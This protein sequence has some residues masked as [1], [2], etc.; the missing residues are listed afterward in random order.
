MWGALGGA[1]V[2][3]TVAWL[4]ALDLR[5]R[6]RVERERERIED[7]ADRQLDRDEA[8][9]DRARER[10]EL[11]RLE[12][13]VELRRK[14]RPTLRDITD[15]LRD[16][17]LADVTDDQAD[18]EELGL[19]IAAQLIELEPRLEGEDHDLVSALTRFIQWPSPDANVRDVWLKLEYYMTGKLPASEATAA[20]RDNSL[21]DDEV[22]AE[23]W[24]TLNSGEI[25]L[26]RPGPWLA[27]SQHL[28]TL[29]MLVRRVRPVPGSI[30]I[31]AVHESGTRACIGHDSQYCALSVM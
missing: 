21:P 18:A 30:P 10:E 13:R 20:A 19:S 25:V 6:D 24:K 12:S 15:A 4:F 23:I 29:M 1:V 8:R 16:L 27:T 9:A 11:A 26:R 22:R 7:R 17:S 3:A 5:R 2:G 14:A 31:R 28:L